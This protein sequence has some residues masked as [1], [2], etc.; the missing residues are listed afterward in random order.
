MIAI[1]TEDISLDDV[2]LG[3]LLLDDEWYA[4]HGNDN[5]VYDPDVKWVKCDSHRH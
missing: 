3:A 1:D 2:F 5:R 4:E